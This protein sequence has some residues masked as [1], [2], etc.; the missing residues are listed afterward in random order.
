MLVVTAAGND[1]P[2]FRTLV[3]P[4][5]ADSVITVGAEDSLGTLAGFSSR[6]PTA[7]GRLKPDL[8]APGVLVCA[9]NG[10]NTVRRLSGTSFATPLVAAA[11]ALLKQLHPALGP[12]ALRRALAAYADHRA[13]PHSLPALGRPDVAAIAAFR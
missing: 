10:P 1:G 13:A 11:A 12:G 8:T 5:D 2:G 3:T 4:G 9:L 6:G 7:D